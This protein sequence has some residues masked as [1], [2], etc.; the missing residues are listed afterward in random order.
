[1][2]ATVVFLRKFPSLPP[3]GGSQSVWQYGQGFR[4]QHDRYLGNSKSG[5]GGSDGSKNQLVELGFRHITVFSFSMSK[6]SSLTSERE[7][8]AES[9][10]HWGKKRKGGHG[11]LKVK[12]NW[13][14]EHQAD[15]AFI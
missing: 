10:S 8:E 5:P 7:K 9:Y 12:N 14:W 4:E 3:S 6:F 13:S 1:M 2:W 15:H 11:S